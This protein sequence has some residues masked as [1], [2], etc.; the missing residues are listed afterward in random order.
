MRNWTHSTKA[1]PKAFFSAHWIKLVLIALV[2]VFV[3][4]LQLAP[5][6]NDQRRDSGIFAYT[7]K[8]IAE[9]GLPYVD[10]WDN[11]LPGVYY[12]DALAFLLFGT[13]RWALWLIENFTLVVT[14]VILSRLLK[15]TFQERTKLWIGPLLLVMFVRHPG[16]ISDVNFTEPYALLPQVVVF[17]AGYQFLRTSDYRW[18]F[19]IGFAAAVALLIK[20]TTVGVALMFVPAIVISRHPVLGTSARWRRLTVIVLGGLTCLG[21]AA[22]FLLANGI[23]DDALDASFVAATSFHEWVSEGSSWIG[24][25]IFTT[26]TATTFPLVF[27]PFLPFIAVGIGLAIRR[28]RARPYPNRQ[29]ATDA[30]LAIWA[31]LTFGL[32]VVLA[33]ITNRGYAH[34][35]VTPVPAAILLVMLSLPT[36]SR[37]AARGGFGIRLGVAALR[38]ELVAC[39]IMVPV[40]AS[41]VRFWMADWSI[42]GPERHKSLA[43]YV[44]ENT[45]LDD[46]VLVWGVDTAI[47][48]QSG[49][50]SPTAYNYGYP[51]VVPDEE[52]GENIRKMVK[53]LERNKPVM[54]VDTTLRD[55]D[56]IPPLN[57]LLRQLWWI[58]GGRRDIERL[59]PIYRFVESYCHVATE[60]D[61][62]IIYRCRYPVRTGLPVAPLI[63]PPAQA[64]V[65]FWN[66]LVDTYQTPVEQAIS[67][68]GALQD[69]QP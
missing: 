18:G 57:P 53:D 41:L 52:S 8:I 39:F 37:Y 27:G 44:T 42:T 16:L 58:E 6:I 56:R 59:D 32:D 51:L 40:V 49:R 65:D 1:R 13:N 22:V 10:A 14:A 48:F 33:N 4:S 69:P 60:Y 11:K 66:Y 68:A 19:L 43:T 54:I 36:M 46:T 31:A 5:S 64:A 2:L 50:N 12:I 28:V 61:R 47:N 23:L 62:A 67:E 30:T 35:Y 55:G 34:Y 63:D 45:D 29:A 25:T 24:G 26:M 15:Q 7:G 3:I 17:A 21:F 38:L 9:G 20:Q